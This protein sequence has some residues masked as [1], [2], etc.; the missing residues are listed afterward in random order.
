[1]RAVHACVHAR[2]VLG[3]G[4]EIHVESLLLSAQLFGAVQVLPVR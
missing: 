1:M 4:I 3:V 2:A